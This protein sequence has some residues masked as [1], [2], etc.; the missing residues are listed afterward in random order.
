VAKLLLE[1]GLSL[2]A[3]AFVAYLVLQ[4]LPVLRTVSHL[5]GS[6]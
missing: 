6:Q 5:L 1:L 3:L 4:I 2:S